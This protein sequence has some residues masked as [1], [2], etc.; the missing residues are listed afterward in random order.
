L[1]P[2]SSSTTL[3]YSGVCWPLSAALGH[4][5]AWLLYVKTLVDYDHK[6]TGKLGPSDPAAPHH[7]MQWLDWQAAAPRWMIRAPLRA[8][9]V[10]VVSAFAFAQAFFPGEHRGPTLGA[11][12]LPPQ[13]STLP[14]FCGSP[15]I[16]RA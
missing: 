10:V 1:S 4:V 8:L 14:A 7:L 9:V 16:A 3:G 6:P 2:R 15:N 13:P 11:A 12:A 5:W